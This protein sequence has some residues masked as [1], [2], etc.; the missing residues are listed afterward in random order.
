V[1]HDT[2]RGKSAVL[3]QIDRFFRDGTIVQTCA[4]PC[5]PE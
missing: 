4:G 1:V 3:R 5:D 2:L